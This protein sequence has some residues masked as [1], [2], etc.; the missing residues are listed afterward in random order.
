MRRANR[1]GRTLTEMDYLLGVN[2]KTR[3]GALRFSENPNGPYLAF[4]ENNPVPPLIKLPQLLRAAEK[5]TGN[6]ENADELKLL[7]APGSSLGGA[8][9]KASVID[10]NGD[11][12]I[13]KFPQK[14]DDCDVVRWEAA[15]LTLAKLAGINVPRWRLES[16]RGKHV[17]IIS[18]FDRR[19]KNRLPF[20]SAMSM[21]AAAD[22]DGLVHSY[23][24]IAN[25]I[26]QHGAQP[27]KDLEELWRRMVFGIMIS[28]TDD[29]LRNHGFLYSAGGWTLSPVYDINP[30]TEK[31]NFAT[32]IDSTGAKNT[33]SLA[34][35]TAENFRLSNRRAKDI[36]E[37]VKTAVSNWRKAAKSLGISE[38]GITKMKSAFNNEAWDN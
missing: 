35:K 18:R 12:A 37:R 15:A 4:S 16:I 28:N 20:L 24:E 9:P 6:S 7:L 8:R 26:I 11:L 33:A 38:H 25:A 32:A 5:F 31:A 27:D 13:A 3:Q 2:D 19:G 14:G 10:K 29:H 21:L 1:S 17:L 36:L 30:N 22:N 23:T 34:L